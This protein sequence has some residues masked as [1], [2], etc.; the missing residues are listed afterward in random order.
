MLASARLL[1]DGQLATLATAPDGLGLTLFSRSPIFSMT[2]L[3]SGVIIA[4]P[5]V[6][7][8]FVE[9]L[10]C[11][12]FATSGA[13]VCTTAPNFQMGNNATE[14]NL[15]S[16]TAPSVAA[17]NAVIA[18]GFPA[19]LVALGVPSGTT[20]KQLI[21][22]ATAATVK[23]TVAGVGTGGFALSGYMLTTFN[24]RPV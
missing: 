7:G 6:P 15:A 14:D 22:L 9:G 2:A 5:S 19:K 4:I 8:Y 21:N 10:L 3:S 23:V 24:L 12:A 13:G 11:S 18:A 17:V 20:A 16:A 1:T